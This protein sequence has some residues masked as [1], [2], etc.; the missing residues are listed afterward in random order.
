MAEFLKFKDVSDITQK[1]KKFEVFS[2]HDGSYLGH[3]YWRNGWRRYVMHFDYDCD[4]SVECMAQCYKFI[5][6]LMQDRNK[7]KGLEPDF[8]EKLLR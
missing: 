8:W 3:I 2:V 7:Q 5:A 6:K 1:T 4:W